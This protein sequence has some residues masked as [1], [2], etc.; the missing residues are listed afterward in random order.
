MVRIRHQIAYTIL[1][2]S[3]VSKKV[4]ITYSV[5]TGENDRQERVARILS[6]G[7]YEYLKKSGFLREEAERREKIGRLLKEGKKVEN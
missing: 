1:G 4:E 7:V 2:K 6:G 3:V 5:V